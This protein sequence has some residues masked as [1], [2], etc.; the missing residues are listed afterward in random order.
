MTRALSLTCLVLAA[1]AGSAWAGKPTI[2]VLGLEV[3]DSSG[4]PTPADTQV[5]HELT[6]ELRNRAQLSNGPYTLQPG[7]DKELIDEKLLNNCDTEDKVC[8]SSI[9]NSL[10]AEKLLFG[11]IEKQG[12]AYSVTL[13]LLDTRHKQ[14]EK[15]V[16]NILIPISQASGAALKSWAKNIYSNITGGPSSGTIVVRVANA[17]RGTI[18]IN[19]EARGNITNST[20]QVTGLEE[21]KY[22][23]EIESQGF[24]PFS[25]EV[26][27]KGDSQTIPVTLEKAE[28]GGGGDTGIGPGGT[29]PTGPEGPIDTGGGGSAGNATWRKVFYGS[30]A[31]GLA[32]GGLWIAGKHVIDSASDR[33][34]AI[35]GYQDPKFNMMQCQMV[36][37]P[38][39]AAAIQHE[40]DR[41]D[42][43][44]LMTYIGGATA[45]AAGGFAL[46]ALYEGFIAK[47]GGSSQEHAMGHR[48][49]RD[50]FVVTPIVSPNGGGATL[51]LS[52]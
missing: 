2:G 34:C 25:Q 23:L 16:P 27:V 36:A 41:G 1:F 24:K 30:V 38:D 29:G 42:K 14:F 43:G 3:V 18:L 48:V 6:I 32:G 33:L 10:N 26:T 12:K 46:F 40:N 31:V 37:S 44:K 4:T 11:K 7:A 21:G 50:R 22:T 13:K 19:H 47:K 20:G 35:G 8:M 9:G 17:D 39:G 28:S 51:Q 5:A 49:H 15:S 45:I 52:W